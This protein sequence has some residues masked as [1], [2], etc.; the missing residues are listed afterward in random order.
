[1][2]PAV[3]PHRSAHLLAVA[4]AAS[5]LGLVG[6]GTI[7]LGWQLDVVVLTSVLPGRV[8]MNPVTALGFLL[9]AAALWWSLPHSPAE[10]PESS[11]AARVA[12]VLLVLIGVVTLTG[13]A[14][15]GNIG[16]DQILFRQRLAGN[17]IAP[18]TGVSFLL[19]GTAIGLLDWEPRRRYRPAQVVV[20]ALAGVALTSVLGYLYGVGELYGVARY[21]PMALP[22]A[23]AFLALSIGTLCARPDAGLMRVVTS[24]EAGGVLARRLLPAAIIIPAGLGWLRHVAARAEFIGMALSLAIV[25]VLTILLFTVLIWVTARTL[26]RAER[27]RKAGELRLAA[28]YATTH[29]LVEAESLADAMPRVLQAVGESLDWVMG[30]RWSV[31]HEANVLRCAEMWIAPPRTLDEFAGVNRRLT[32]SSGVGLPGRVWKS[33]TAQWIADVVRDPNFPRAPHAARE[34]LHGAFGFPIVGPGGFLGVMEFFSPEIR[35]PDDDLLKM[36]EGVGGQVG[37]FIERKRAEAELE[38]AR[39]AAE[40]ATRAKSEFLANMSHEI[41]TPM[42]AIIGMGTLLLDTVL[43]GRQREFAE[44]IRASG[45]HLLS[46]IDDILDFS[47]IESGR[48][49]LEQMPFR[50]LVC[51][52]ESVQLVAPKAQEKRLELTCLVEDSVPTALVGDAA[53]VRQILVNLLSNAVKFTPAGEVDVKVTATLLEDRRHEIHFTV[54]DTGIGIPPDRFHRLFQSFSQVDASTTRRYG[55]T[56]LGL[57]ISKRLAELMGGRIWADSDVGKG[58]TFHFT[59]VAESASP[60]ADVPSPAVGSVLVG[61]RVLIVDD[62]RTNRRILQLQVEKWGL[63]ARETESPT[64]ALEWIQQGDPYDLVLVDYQM[65]EMDGIALAKAIRQLPVARS[66][67]L[68][69]LSS[70]AQALAVE[71]GEAGFAAVLSKPVRLSTLQDRLCEI[72]VD[73]PGATPST[74]GTTSGEPASAPLRILVAEDNPANQ[75]VAIRLLERLGHQA[76]LAASGREVLELISRSPYDV[77]FMDVQMPEMDGLEATRAICARWPAGARPRIIAMT[78][79][80]MEG[81]RQACLAAGMDDYVVKPVRL[82]RLSRALAQC[83]PVP[84]QGGMTAPS[85]TESSSPAVLDHRVLRELESELGGADGLRQVIVTFLEGSPRFL[86]GLRDAAARGD[87]A[88]MRQAAHALKSSSALLGAMALSS[89]CEELEG[90]SRSGSVADPVARVAAIETLYHAVTLGLQTEAAGLAIS[91]GAG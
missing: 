40:T 67:A 5:V 13:Y 56:G 55:G 8:A 83:R 15:G 61:K 87:V 6:G 46:I 29:I 31:D 73:R 41:R 34:G 80:A 22:T 85:E 78:A 4:R 39:I 63:R 2:T 66:L 42:N 27:K 68:V 62:N 82:D 90:E 60:P 64:Q 89:R 28:Q 26:N 14:I 47:K 38:R 10:D 32:F 25:V 23:L 44:T 88:G 57:A 65:P 35:E 30:A 81:D 45:D 36:F 12:A 49:E 58:S 77:I 72:F 48:L 54:R 71:P 74:P 76:D 11:R 16:L 33:G 17:R 20:L 19:L 70:T 51:V 21:I 43:D 1:M 3:D 69:L 18:N 59:I 52:E 86:A 79:E 50:P 7:L 9:A 37:Q 24:D 84:S 75:Q 91:R 53:R